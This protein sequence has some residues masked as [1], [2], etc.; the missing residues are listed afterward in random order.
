MVWMSGPKKRERT[1]QRRHALAVAADHRE[2]NRRRIG[3][4]RDGAREIGQ[5]QPLG[6]IGDL[7][8]RER[9]PACSNAAGDVACA[10]TS[11]LRLCDE[12]GASGGTARCRSRREPFA[13]RSPRRKS[14]DRGPRASTSY[15]SRSAS[16][17]FAI[18]ASAKRPSTRSISRM[19]RCQERNSSLRRRS[20]SPSLEIRV[21]VIGTAPTP[22]TRTG[23]GR[24]YIEGFAG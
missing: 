7:G 22:K 10:L 18:C 14:A 1:R 6:A 19:P 24:G 3:L 9:W 8:Q 20:S 23:P 16:L 21:P 17:N 4:R 11:A 15:S 13:S 2:R 5:H 12:N